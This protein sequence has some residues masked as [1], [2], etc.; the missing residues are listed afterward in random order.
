MIRIGLNTS[1]KEKE[2]NKIVSSNGIEKIYVIYF[3]KT[4]HTFSLHDDVPIEYIE[5]ADTEM[6]KYFYRLLAEIN[7]KSLIVIDE[8]MRSTAKNR[9]QLK[10]NCIHHY[11][12]QTPNRLIFEYFPFIETPEDFMILMDF[13]DTKFKL[14]HF[15]PIYLSDIDFAGKPRMLKVNTIHVPITDREREIYQKEAERLFENLGSKDPETIPSALQ[16]FVGK[17]KRQMIDDNQCYMARN[18][19]F[20]RSNILCYNDVSVPLDEPINCT[21]I[22][23]P[24]RRLHF[25]DFLKNAKQT[26]IIFLSTD[27]SVDK[28]ITDELARIEYEKEAFYAQTG[29]C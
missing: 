26:S 15:D 8:I 23:I 1:E 9:K 22:D 28:V 6:Y 25:N 16:L 12:N 3:K 10:Y 17:Y 29:I 11:L 21:L 27:L 14:H 4:K 13:E 7:E 5:F 18:K 24:L 19:R 2:I 20:K